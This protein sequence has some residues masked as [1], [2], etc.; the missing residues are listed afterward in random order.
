MIA[1]PD[2]ADAGA[3][4]VHCGAANSPPSLTPGTAPPSMLGKYR[5]V[6]ELGRG[7]MGVVY[8][9]EDP[10]LR[11]RI[12]L[13]V[14]HLV[15]ENE[16]GV[17]R[18]EREARA[19]ASLSHPNVVAVHEIGSV[20]GAAGE[21]AYHFIAME[22]VDGP[23][24][25]SAL[26]GLGLEERVRVL[27]DVAEGVGHAHSRGVIHRDLKPDNVLLSNDGRP[28]V[29]DF[30]L[31][32]LTQGVTRLTR[33]G[34]LIGTPSFMAPEQ[35]R[36]ENRKIV[37]ATDVWSLGVMLYEALTGKLPFTGAVA[38]AVFSA[39]LSRDPVPPRQH[40]PRVAPALEAICLRCLEKD[41]AARYADAN[42][43]AA[44]LDRHLRGQA[45]RARTRG[46]SSTLRR[47]VRRRGWLGVV[48][49][50]VSLASILLVTLALWGN[51]PAGRRAPSDDLRRATE[52]YAAGDLD[53]AGAA[54]RRAL[55]ASPD[56][57]DAKYWSGRLLLRGWLRDRDAPEA[58]RIDGAVLLPCRLPAPGADEAARR[59]IRE[60]L[61]GPRGEALELG[62]V[63]FDEERFEDALEI[64]ESEGA[65]EAEGTRWEFDLLAA[66][67]HYRL[68]RFDRAQGLLEGRLPLDPRAIGP[69]WT[70]TLLARGLEARRTGS[71]ARATFALAA[72][73]AR[74]ARRSGLDP[75]GRLLEATAW[76]LAAG[77]RR[78]PDP[79]DHASA[80]HAALADLDLPEA[81]LLQGDAHVAQA[82]VFRE[83]G[84]LDRR[85]PYE[86]RVAIEEYSR[87]LEAEPR[88]IRA[89]LRRADA[90]RARWSLDRRP[91][92]DRLADASSAEADYRA[93]LEIDPGS[94]QAAIGLAWA[95]SALA[96]FEGRDEDRRVAA[97]RA[98]V[99]ELA[100][101]PS[102][103]RFAAR[104]QARVG[105]GRLLCDIRRPARDEFAA[106]VADYEQALGLDPANPELLRRRGSAHL[107]LASA[108]KQEQVSPAPILADA[109]ED[110][111]DAIAGDPGDSEALALRGRV[112]KE[113]GIASDQVE[114]FLAAIADF[115]EASALRPDRGDHLYEKGLC[116]RDYALLLT[117]QG[118]D[119]SRQ[120]EGA[121]A[122]LTRSAELDPSW[123]DA[124]RIKAMVL[125]GLGLN[126]Q[127]AI[128][129]E[130][131]LRVDAEYAAKNIGIH[132]ALTTSRL[133]A[134]YDV[135]EKGGDPTSWFEGAIRAAGDGLALIP[136]H[137]E[138][139]C[140]RGLAYGGL[141]EFAAA[142][143][144]DPSALDE[145][146]YAELH[147]WANSV[148]SRLA[149][150]C[151]AIL[152]G[153]ERRRH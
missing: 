67:C 18:F 99:E 107:D 126:E 85:D 87:A 152:Q 112:R 41:S 64:F 36:G 25:R 79:E 27:R 124:Y 4:C 141:A 132:N 6:R 111:D 143:G 23:T 26:D 130:P 149:S 45:V 94:T 12:A 146:A 53:A 101:P 95:R 68:R 92:E 52:A 22:Y 142:R 98:E 119:A 102:V 44:D 74:A 8:E 73:S 76:I 90:L 104:A 16:R 97:W 137:A 131:A 1:Y 105:L 109:L 48:A 39:I 46:W 108:S 83:R 114:E 86:Y 9:A 121:M 82:A 151:E 5:I 56:D 37:P 96:R 66:H 57:L 106:A 136:D 47:R 113:R 35:V 133:W 20:S 58:R 153:I 84:R 32:T 19:C 14:L 31:A 15:G 61:A 135:L 80:A 72:G 147:G 17:K 71:D 78:G 127:A 77:D 115:A 93:A 75:L 129:C 123:V 51:D 89:R 34:A 50:A 60:A 59:A 145:A 118:K 69:L 70:R 128:A 139:H 144:A 116:E 28:V 13:K 110:L 55:D 81:H 138:I 40:S 150:Q 91:D 148:N 30:G 103:E 134:G 88:S 65:K 38:P 43:L 117:R 2:P 125:Q 11:R 21:G 7:G 63:A 42:G 120:W 62:L 10:T 24:L 100:G 140:Y 54:I 122:D 33:S 3:P 49:G 29:T